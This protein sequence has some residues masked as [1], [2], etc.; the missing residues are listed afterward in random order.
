MIGIP[1]DAPAA[2]VR[3]T[4]I[5]F[6]LLKNAL[7]SWEDGADWFSLA[8]KRI[9]DSPDKTSEEITVGFATVKLI[10]IKQL[11]ICTLSVS[12]EE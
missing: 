9:T 8:L 11:G 4:G 12:Y 6:I 1:N 5:C 10:L 7:P 2:L 3:N